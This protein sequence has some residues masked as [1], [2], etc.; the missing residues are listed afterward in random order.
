MKNIFDKSITEEVINRINSLTP[1]SES[2]WG[3]MTVAQMLSHCNVTYELVYEDIHPKPNPIMKLILKLF[4]KSSVVGEK[5]YKHGLPTASQ[6]LIKEGKEFGKEKIRLINYLKKTQELG[7]S[8]FD[9]RESNSF[10]KLTSLEWNNMFYKH[11]DHHLKQFG[12]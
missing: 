2:G 4:I 10:G 9:G 12:V 5:P 3:K 6:F 8:Y 11:L 1:E 7:E